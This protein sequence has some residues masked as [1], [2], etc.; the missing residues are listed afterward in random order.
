MDYYKTLGV[1]KNATP[2]EIKKAYRKLAS[3]YHPDKG[4]DTKR[5][6]EIQLAYD[7]L[8]DPQKKQQYDNPNP[9]NG[10]AQGFPGGFHFNFTSGEFQDI[11]SSFFGQQSPFQR[12][13]K[14]IFRTK[15]SVSLLDAYNGSTQ[16]LQI[17]TGEGTKVLKINIPRGVESGTQLRYDNI[18]DSATLIIEFQ[19]LPDLKFDRRGADL[20]CNQPISVLDLI[21]GTK[22]DF[23]T[24]SG[25]SITVNVNPKTQPN[26]QLKISGEGMPTQNGV[27]GDQI[28]LLKPFIPDNISDE[29]INTI[30][31]YKEQ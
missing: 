30:N 26:M 17:Q 13:Y 25:K 1:N 22:I 7:T 9:F 12:Q 31:K 11:F 16:T 4:G 18:L 27:F 14:Q 20:Y 15:V 29:L 10:Q 2:D 24:L 23:K 8:S 28:L 19:V 3:Q 21:T 6:Q 5:F